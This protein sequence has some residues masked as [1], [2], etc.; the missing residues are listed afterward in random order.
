[1]RT[2]DNSVVISV[3][4]GIMMSFIVVT[5]WLVPSV[6]IRDILEYEA[7]Y[8]MSLDHCLSMSISVLQCIAY[9]TW[10]TD[11]HLDRWINTCIKRHESVNAIYRV[12]PD[13][14]CLKMY[15]VSYDDY[16]YQSVKHCQMPPALKGGEL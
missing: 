12:S 14:T 5:I 11:F 4:L 16:I 9:A 13:L 8:S 10:V 15:D 2:A 1:M 7:T 3:A 6:I